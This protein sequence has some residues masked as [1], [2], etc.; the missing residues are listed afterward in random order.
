MILGVPR[1]C[2]STRSQN[3][4][5]LMDQPP[6]GH[7]APGPRHDATAKC[8]APRHRRLTNQSAAMPRWRRF[9]GIRASPGHRSRRQ[10]GQVGD[11]GVGPMAEQTRTPGASLPIT[12]SSRIRALRRGSVS[13]RRWPNRVERQPVDQALVPNHHP[14]ASV[15]LDARQDQQ[16]PDDLGALMALRVLVPAGLVLWAAIAWLLVHLFT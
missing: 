6:S 9:G 11:G 14:A 12:R 4:D 10:L 2:R 8:R 15:S 7:P 13:R 5:G 1:S 3:E 16:S